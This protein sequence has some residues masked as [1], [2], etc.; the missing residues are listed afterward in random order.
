MPR[1]A[2]PDKNKVDLIKITL[3][4]SSRPLH[5]RELARRLG[6]AMSYQTICRYLYEFMDD[7]VLLEARYGPNGDHMTFVSLHELGEF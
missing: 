1:K 6:D 7:E 2:G 4:A 5:I 3:G